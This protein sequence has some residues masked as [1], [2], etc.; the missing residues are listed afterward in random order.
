MPEEFYTVEESAKILRV[1]RKTVYD[2]MRAGR[3]P[4]VQAGLR[5]RLIPKEALNQ[6]KRTWGVGL[7]VDRDST[8]P[9]DIQIPSLAAA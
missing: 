9:D 2:W 6:F 4:Y 3:L 1:S 5:K 7:D 8:I